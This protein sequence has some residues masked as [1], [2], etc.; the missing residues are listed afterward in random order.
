MPISGS[1]RRKKKTNN[2]NIAV[3]LKILFVNETV[4]PIKIFIQSFE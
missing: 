2:I 3:I 4:K 1:V